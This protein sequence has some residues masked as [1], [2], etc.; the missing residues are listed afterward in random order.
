[1]T[2]RRLTNPKR[3]QREIVFVDTRKRLASS[4][5]VNTRSPTTSAGTLAASETSS[6]KSR[7]S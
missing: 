2:N 7:K 1:M 4:S 5:T 6:T 3:R